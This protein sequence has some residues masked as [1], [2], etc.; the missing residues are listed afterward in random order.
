M[1]GLV[2]FFEILQVEKLVLS[3]CQYARHL[4]GVGDLTEAR[5]S[6]HEGE[7][8]WK[9]DLGRVSIDGKETAHP[10]APRHLRS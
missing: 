5:G 8:K 6:H 9:L 2:I 1:R 10:G 4:R 3:I 7:E